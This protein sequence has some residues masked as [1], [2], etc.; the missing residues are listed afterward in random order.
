[1]ETY[2][3]SC[4]C[5]AVRFR[6]QSEPI[7]AGFTCNCSICTRKGSTVSAAYY[8]PAAVEITHGRAHLTDYRF[9]PREVSHH[10]CSTCGIHVLIE[11]LA[12]PDDYPG[13][14]RAGDLRINLRCVDGI[15]LDTLAISRLD[16]RSF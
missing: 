4:H 16:G 2:S 14:A 9:G 10:F 8:R 7:V 15:D 12:I 13:P 5:G 3:G 6:F 1:M 11:V